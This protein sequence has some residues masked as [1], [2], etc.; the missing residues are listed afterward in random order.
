MQ[1][2]T[3]SQFFYLDIENSLGRGSLAKF[4][5]PPY[6]PLLP[7]CAVATVIRRRIHTRWRGP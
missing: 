6:T 7:P 1:K 4:K 5:R 3:S 2:K